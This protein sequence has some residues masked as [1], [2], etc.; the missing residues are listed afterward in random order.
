MTLTF[1][2]KRLGATAVSAAPRILMREP[3]KGFRVLTFHS[4]GHPVDGDPYVIY[5]MSPTEFGMQIAAINSFSIK[6]SIPLVPFDSNVEHGIAITFD[7]GYADLLTTVAPLLNELQIPF[8][9]FITPTKLTSGDPRYLTSEQLK[10][11]AA[12]PL[13]SVGA[14]GYEHRP[15]TTMS[16][17]EAEHDLWRSR[18]SLEE[19]LGVSVTSMSYPFGN[20][21]PPIRDAVERSGF[22]RAA[23][24]KWGFNHRDTDPLMLRRID[25]WARDSASTVV[26]KV[27]GNWNWF[28]RFT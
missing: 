16:T 9:L 20:V 10:E 19:L 22:S 13:V 17:S 7:D 14:H 3:P 18:T 23:C 2:I 15:L 5:N 4:I 21:D 1:R 8:H 24:S 28:G 27:C 26:D 6:H 11:L 12:N 25:M